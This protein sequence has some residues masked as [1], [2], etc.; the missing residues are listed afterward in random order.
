MFYSGEI[1]LM[2]YKER[3]NK[4]PSFKEGPFLFIEECGDRHPPWTKVGNLSV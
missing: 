1:T 3:T 2:K 4:R